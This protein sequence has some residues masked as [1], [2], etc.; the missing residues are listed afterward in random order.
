MSLDFM[1]IIVKDFRVVVFEG[2]KCCIKCNKF[3]FDVYGFV[4]QGVDEIYFM[5]IFMFNMVNYCW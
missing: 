4:M 5:Y 2:I 1:K 3:S